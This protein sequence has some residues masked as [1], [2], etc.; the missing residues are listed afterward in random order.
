MKTC[1]TLEAFRVEDVL[2]L[3]N[4]DYYDSNEAKEL[5]FKTLG[6]PLQGECR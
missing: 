1:A 6:F 5:V 3:D 2:E 4:F